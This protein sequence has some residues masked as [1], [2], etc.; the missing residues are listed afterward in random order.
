MA[1]ASRYLCLILMA[2][3][4]VVSGVVGNTPSALG[5]LTAVACMGVEETLH[6]KIKKLQEYI[7]I[8]GKKGE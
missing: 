5:W 3:N 8:M 7:V 6:Q 1:V 4:G 2:F